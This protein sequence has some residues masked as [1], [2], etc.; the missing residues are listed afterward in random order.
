MVDP[1]FRAHV[2]KIGKSRGCTYDTLVINYP[3]P[4]V[5]PHDEL[6]DWNRDECRVG[7]DAETRATQ[8][9][10]FSKPTGDELAESAEILSG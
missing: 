7:G 1:I 5:G 8:V 2:L 10:R 3:A 9:S 6:K 4:V